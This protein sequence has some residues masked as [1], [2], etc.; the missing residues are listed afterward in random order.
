MP[1]CKSL[2]SDCTRELETHI[3]VPRGS[4]NTAAKRVG[5]DLWLPNQSSYLATSK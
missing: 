1:N 5:L 4:G 3:D 2:H